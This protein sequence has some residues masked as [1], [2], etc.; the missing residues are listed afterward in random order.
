L[1][2]AQVKPL[3]EEM[4]RVLPD[5]RFIVFE[6]QQAPEAEVMVTHAM[7]ARTTAG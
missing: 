2:W 6:P 4:S 3:I 5:V 7:P 1:A